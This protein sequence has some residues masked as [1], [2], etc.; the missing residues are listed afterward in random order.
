MLIA[1]SCVASVV[2][3]P[4]TT[5]TSFI[6]GTG[7]KKCRP[8]NRPGSETH[9]ASLVM[10]TEDVLVLIRASSRTTLSTACRI[11]TLTSA[12]SVAASTTRSA[13][14]R[15]VVSV[16]AVTRLMAACLESAL[17]CPFAT[18]RPKPDPMRSIALLSAVSFTSIRITG[19]PQP[20]ATCAMPVP[21]VPAPTIPIVRT[22]I[23][24]LFRQFAGPYPMPAL[25]RSRRNP[26]AQSAPFSQTP[27]LI[28]ISGAYCRIIVR[29][30]CSNS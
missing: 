16:A 10:E 7:L 20:A 5:S 8:I 26:Y 15:A 14:A 25:S 1:A 23:F 21:I 29:Y 27:E 24:V 17:I 22:H 9:A 18:S 30:R 4:R 3:K 6:T 12:F 11:L 2:C 19:N 28:V 13:G